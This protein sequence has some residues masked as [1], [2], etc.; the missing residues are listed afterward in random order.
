MSSCPQKMFVLGWRVRKTALPSR[1][2]INVLSIVVEKIHLNAASVGTLHEPV[3]HVPVVRADEFRMLVTVEIDGLNGVEFE[4]PGYAL[5]GLGA[6]DFSKGRCGGPP[7]ASVKPT[8]YAFV[9]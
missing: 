2:K 8:S 1:V 7:H 3:V 4:K 6:Y 9:F 5:F